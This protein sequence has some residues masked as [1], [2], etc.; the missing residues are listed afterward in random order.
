MVR[1]YPIDVKQLKEKQTC[2]ADFESSWAVL[3]GG[4]IGPGSKVTGGVS[5]VASRSLGQIPHCVKLRRERVRGEAEK[6]KSDS[7]GAFASAREQESDSGEEEKSGDESNDD[8]VF[9]NSG[10]P[11]L[12][13]EELSA[14]SR[15]VRFPMSCRYVLP[16]SWARASNPP[17]GHFTMFTA[18]FGAGFTIP[19]DLLLVEELELLLSVESF[20]SLFLL[21]KVPKEPFFYFFPRPGCKFL[22]G[23]LSSWGPWN[24]RFF[25]ARNEGWDFP[26]AWSSSA[27]LIKYRKCHRDLCDSF[28]A[29]GLFEK[30]F[31]VSILFPAGILLIISSCLRLPYWYLLTYCL[32]C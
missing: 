30:E 5:K 28:E 27:S 7:T 13:V 32:S 22:S 3:G 8:G 21:K 6:S 19:P 25:F 26:F 23:V 11:Q 14:L 10:L 12:T 20:Q 15:R 31:D 16:S 9:D 2:G 29:S 4:D 1:I 18:Y 24:G 17:R